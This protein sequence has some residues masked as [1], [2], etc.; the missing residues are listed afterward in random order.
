MN[1]KFVFTL[2]TIFLNMASPIAL[3]PTRVYQEGDRKLYG[4]LSYTHVC[5]GSVHSLGYSALII[6]P[7]V[8]RHCL[9][10]DTR[11]RILST[12]EHLPHS[13]VDELVSIVYARERAKMIHVA[14]GTHDRG[15]E[16]YL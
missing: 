13:I 5:R 1:E 14:N 6:S 16:N 2:C 9:A 11:A 15:H 12:E 10:T 4:K 7:K 8:K 3:A